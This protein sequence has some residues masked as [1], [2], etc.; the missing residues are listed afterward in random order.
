MTATSAEF[1]F[2]TRE[3][4]L[5][6]FKDEVFDLLVIGGGITGAATARDAMS[7][8]L[9]VA[10][11]EKGDFASGTS[12]RSSKL[13]HGGLRYLQNLELGLVFESLRE[14]TLL[15]KTVPHMVRPLRFYVPVYRGDTNGVAVVSIGLWLYDLLTLFRTPGLHRRL[16]RKAFIK[17]IPNIRQEGLVGG[18]RYY[19]ASMWDDVL[20]VETA[21]AASAGGAAIASYVEAIAPLWVGDRIRG[22]RVRDL[23]ATGSAAEIN[24]RAHRVIVCAGPWTDQMGAKISL[25][26]KPWLNPSK[27]VHLIFDLKKIPVPGALVMAHPE[28]GRISFV[29]PRPDFGAGIT[30]VGTTDGPTPLDPEKAEVE[31]ADVDYLFDL[32]KKY[33]PKLVL[34]TSDILSA[35][36]GVRPLFT[37]ATGSEG[38]ANAAS[39]QKVSREHHIG[40]GPGGTVLV[41][42]GK[43]TTHRKMAEEIVEFVL[44][45]WRDDVRDGRFERYPEV[46]K[47]SL[48]RSRTKTPVNP[49]ATTESVQECIALAKSENVSIAPELLD[50]YGGEAL[51][52]VRAAPASKTLKEDPAG[53][54]LL[55]AQ[56]RHTIRSEMVMHLED[57]YLRRI[58]LY[59]T[60][61]DHGVPWAETLARV[62]ATERGIDEPHV[63]A[64]LARLQSEIDRRSRWQKNL[65]ERS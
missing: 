53:F 61:T 10:L 28:D 40:M 49:L 5:K 24:V 62:W 1:S 9:K 19:D 46:L 58:P 39:L 2:R 17:E 45:S 57:F 3:A 26:W 50:R 11:V 14:R 42:G 48:G 12:S 56:L 8:G 16:S 25:H 33:F 37:E 41:A 22:F 21:R 60:R 13:V 63:R 4:A 59:A 54:P 55:E 30:L 32:L 43:Y 34:T 52:V 64:E 15:L 65:G 29:I 6:R 23:E 36:V 38:Q 7:R 31:R 18:F 27:G 47:W 35:Y 44:R 51:D 20:A